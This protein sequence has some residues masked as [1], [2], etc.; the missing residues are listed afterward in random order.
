VR[1]VLVVNP[2]AGRVR[3]EAR[4][5]DIER[6]LTDAGL[7]VTRLMA[8]DA[9]AV[10][11]AIAAALLGRSPEDTR[12]VVAGGDGT[13][14]SALPALISNPFPVAILPV[15][16]VNVLARALE[17]PLSL[18]AAMRLVAS[19]QVRRLDV[20]LANGR[21]FTL[22]AGMG[23]DAAVVHSVTRPAKRLFG[24]FAYVSRGLGLVFRYGSSRC[25]LAVDGE[26]EEHPTWLAVVTNIPRYT[27]RWQLSPEARADDGLLDLALFRAES[28]G[29]SVR[30]GLS[31]LRGN[32]RYRGIVHRRGRSFQFDFDPPIHVQLDGDPAGFTPLA[33]T[34]APRALSVVVPAD[35]GDR[36]PRHP[37]TNESGNGSHRSR[38]P[39][40]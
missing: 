24:S 36:S 17:I 9:A 10:P 8:L 39:P 13:I 3:T 28:R 34:V 7:T 26:W 6:A 20:G 14:R 23:F 18:P 30:Q 21:P 35:T 5:P 31:V 29:L 25:R 15:G 22:M 38:F 11:D 37:P 40:G 16:S 1:A 33:V 32:P 27:Y 4:V 12:V 2:E 19:G